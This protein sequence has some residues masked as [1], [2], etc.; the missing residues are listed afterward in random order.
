MHE[1]PESHQPDL[2]VG[3]FGDLVGSVVDYALFAMSPEGI[4]L[5]WN[6]GAEQIKGYTSEEI[7]GSHFSRFYSDEDRATGFPDKEL[8]IASEEGHFTTEGWRYRKDGTRFW[9]DV[10]ITAIKDGDGKVQGFLKITRDLTEKM[11]AVEALRQSEERFRLLIEKVEEYAIFMLDPEGHVMSWNAG[12]RRL[13]GYEEAE[14]VGQHFSVFYPPDIRSTQPPALMRKAIKDGFAEAEG[15]RVRKDGSLF[16]GNVVLTALYSADRELRGFAKITR[17][18]TERRKIKE[19]QESERLR[20][21]FLATLAHE[22]RNPLAPVLVGV[23]LLTQSAR[24]PAVIEKVVPMLNRQVKQMSHLIDDLLDV[25]RVSTGKI[26]LKKSRVSLAD[27]IESAVETVAPA[28]EAAGHRFTTRLPS[29]RVEMDADPQRIAQVISNLLSNAVKFTPPGGN[30]ELE[31]AIESDDAVRITVSD[32]GKGVELESQT[33]IFELFE[34]G[35]RGQHGGLGIG[36]TLVRTLTEMHGGTVSMT[37]GGEGSGSQF[38]LLLPFAHFEPAADSVSSSAEPRTQTFLRLSRVLVADDG[39]S[40]ADILALFFR[41]EGMETVVAYDG[42]QAVN[43]AREFHPQVVCL[44]LGMP[45]MD[46]YEAARQI[47]L[48]DRDVVI[49]AL[50]GWGGPDD[51][52]RSAAAGFDF[53]LVKPVSPEDLRTVINQL[54]TPTG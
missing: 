33:R 16:W 48:L 54:V 12:A 10:T 23:E 18:L 50:S 19:M 21:V 45:V 47:R 3:L 42:A 53:H 25:S 46:G 52:R 2:N 51:R 36:L 31:A 40:T 43:L 29:G 32:D 41:M 11:L 49:I 22:L 37:S 4:I 27:I 24:D 38:H 9:A 44:D 20:S 17:D 6:R 28:I 30:I 26:S 34:Q 35:S 39:R 5:N 13:K 8:E 7:V 14:I 1:S 15:W